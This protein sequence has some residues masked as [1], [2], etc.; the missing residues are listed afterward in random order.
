MQPEQKVALIRKA[1][2]LGMNTHDWMDFGVG[3]I[4]G[5][6]QMFDAERGLLITEI[7]QAPRVRYVQVHIGAGELD[8]VLELDR[9]RLDEHARE[10][11]CDFI[12]MTGRLGWERVLPKHGWTRS[13]VVFT[14][15]PHD[16]A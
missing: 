15:V 3:L 14:R 4:D 2:R 10:H 6:Y 13:G 5:R 11:G 12:T 9:T 8:A 7:V 1:C 16:P